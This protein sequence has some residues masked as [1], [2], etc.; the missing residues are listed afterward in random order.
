[1]LVLKY[2]TMEMVM[3]KVGQPIVNVIRKIELR[4]ANLVANDAQSHSKAV[5][6]LS[7]MT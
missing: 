3:E 4:C 7:E 1:L 6:K 2:G 5:E